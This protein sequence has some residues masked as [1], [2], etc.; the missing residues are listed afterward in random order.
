M[1]SEK[2][3]KK[4]EGKKAAEKNSKKTEGLGNEE[5]KES[6][7]SKKNKESKET[8]EPEVPEVIN[9]TRETFGAIDIGSNAIRLLISYVETYADKRT[10]YKKAAFIRV[11]I[12]LGDDV[13]MRGHIS[14]TKVEALSDA[15]QAFAALM[16]AYGVRDCRA[17]ATSAM[18]EAQNGTDVV[19]N[20]KRV[21]GLNIEI[22]SG[23]EEADTIYAA[24]GLK[25]VL[26]PKKNYVYV[27]VGGG[28]TEVVVYA[29]GAK[30]LERSFR[31]GT[32]RMLAGAVSEDEWNEFSSWL[33]A[34]R[35]EWKPEAIIGSGG[36]INKAHKMLEKKRREPIKTKE[37]KQLYDQ[38]R[39]MSVTER[40][41]QLYL[42]Q[43][44]AEVIA[45]ALKIFYTVADKCNI[46]TIMVPRVG[47]VDGIVK[48]LMDKYSK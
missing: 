41:E 1:K 15:M 17:C 28:S 9:V 27:D 13:F 25:E 42:N 48:G 22:I 44:R 29:H 43:S 36:N 46:D 11:P 6:K 16:R 8:S 5:S 20:I 34:V 19:D 2:K 3:E 40:M 10:E 21:S 35:N 4:K 18:R 47:L 37:L 23:E 39:K 32:V 45:N 30:T 33:K 14:S 31:L 24:G 38:T 26:D 7:E 12:R